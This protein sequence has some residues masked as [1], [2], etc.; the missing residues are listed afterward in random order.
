MNSTVKRTIFGVLFLVIMLG[1]LLFHPYLYA[2]LLLFMTGGMLWEFYHITLGERHRPGRL[3][4]ILAG[5]LAF[6]GTFLVT[7]YGFSPR[8]YIPILLVLLLAFSFIPEK[9]HTHFPEASYLFTGL[10]YIA[11]PLA[12]TN[13]L[14]FRDGSYNGLLIVSFFC[15]IW[16]S[17]VGAYCFGM[18]FGQKGGKKMCPSISPKKSWVGFWGG[19]FMAVLAGLVLYLTGMLSFPVWHCLILAAI[20][21]TVGVAGDLFESL[22]KRSFGFKDS[23]NIIPGHG[24]LLDR[25]DSTL[26]AF[27]AGLAYLLLFELI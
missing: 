3:L 15:I 26:F 19:I 25:F 20:M 27:P 17:D 12:L 5:L 2:A 6:L 21:G 9:D 22:W 10:L 14:V 13:L 23:G 1:G 18:L 8:L 11:A 16:S 24:G 7:G 4:A